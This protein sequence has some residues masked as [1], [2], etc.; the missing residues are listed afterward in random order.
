MIRSIDYFDASIQCINCRFVNISN[1]DSKHLLVTM[2]SVH[3]F[4]S[5]FFNV[6][7]STNIIYGQHVL[8]YS[9]HAVRKFVLKNTSFSAIK[10]Y[11]ILKTTPSRNDVKFKIVSSIPTF[12]RNHLL[13][14]FETQSI[15]SA[16]HCQS[17]IAVSKASSPT[18]QSL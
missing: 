1:I 18:Y 12:G 4:D 2:G 13:L 15:K 16:H 14:F 10:A 9:D 6:S 7:I 11:S 3:L 17:Q 8:D 5:E